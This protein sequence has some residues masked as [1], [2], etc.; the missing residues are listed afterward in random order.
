MIDQVP[1]CPGD[2]DGGGAVTVEELIA[3]V[4]V[5]IGT[6]PIS[7]CAAGDSNRDGQITIDEIVVAVN[8]DLNGCR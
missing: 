1:V 8:K 6:S 3:M 5:A 2:C 4:S 7:A